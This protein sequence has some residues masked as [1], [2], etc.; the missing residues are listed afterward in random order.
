MA[1]E[2]YYLAP[3]TR[4][5]LGAELE[6]AIA[7][8]GMRPAEYYRQALLSIAYRHELGIP[9][10]LANASTQTLRSRIRNFVDEQTKT[11]TRPEP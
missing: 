2:R 5:E 3:V 8:V 4:P 7:V 10:E 6:I 1:L 9:S 11:K